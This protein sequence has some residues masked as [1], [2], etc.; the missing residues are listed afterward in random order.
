M[1]IVW[2]TIDMYLNVVQLASFWNLVGQGFTEQ[3][4]LVPTDSFDIRWLKVTF[5]SSARL[6]YLS[7]LLTGCYL[8]RLHARMADN[9]RNSK[10]LTGHP[11]EQTS[12]SSS[13]RSTNQ[14][15]TDWAHLEGHPS[16]KCWHQTQDMHRWESSA[17]GDTRCSCICRGF[18]QDSTDTFVV[19]A[20]HVSDF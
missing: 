5:P 16:R 18:L 1:V 4:W 2:L 15:L 20:T 10:Q 6:F 7:T 14:K 19:F 12:N 11:G 17:S 13:Q 3:C 8:Y 9:V